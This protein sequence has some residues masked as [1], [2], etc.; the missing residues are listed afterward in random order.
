MVD[1]NID[2][3]KNNIRKIKSMK[4]KAWYS[5]PR[6]NFR[7]ALFCCSTLVI[8]YVIDNKRLISL[9]YLFPVHW[10]AKSIIC[11]I[12]VLVGFRFTNSSALPV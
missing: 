6:I 8:C 12:S 5:I 3:P 2:N 10:R 11:H 4:A 1:V 9:T 7:A